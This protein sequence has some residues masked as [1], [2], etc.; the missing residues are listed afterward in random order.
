MKPTLELLTASPEE[1]QAVG[2]A[3]APALA[4]GD[5]ISLTGDLGAGKTTFVQGV[6]P[7]LG[8]TDHVVSPTFTLVREYD[9]TLPVYHFDVYRLD[10]LQE[11]LDLGFE[12]TLD[13]GGIVFIE[14]GDAIEALLPEAYLQ[15]ELTIPGEDSVRRLEITARGPAWA[16]RWDRIV[17]AVAPWKA[18]V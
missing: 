11:V 15:I 7:T 14:W 2:A 9:G 8:V 16:R 1:S 18:P 10:N 5:V 6:A 13:L 4:A 12:E 3:I 17:D